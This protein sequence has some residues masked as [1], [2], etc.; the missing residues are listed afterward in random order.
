MNYSTTI[1]KLETDLY[2]KP[3]DTHQHF[4]AQSCHRNVYKRPTAYRQVVRL[5]RIC[6]IEKKLNSRLEQLKLRMVKHGCKED[7]IDSEIEKVKLVKRTVSFQKR[8]KK[9]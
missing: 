7:H 1:D 2:C 9:S 5:K 3:N 6:S 4:H 8:H